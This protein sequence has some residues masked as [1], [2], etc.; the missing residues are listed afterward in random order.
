MLPELAERDAAGEI[1]RIYE[2]FRHYCAVPYVSSL[3]RHLA[4]RAGWLEWAWAA[5]GPVFV[6]GSGP[7]AAWAAAAEVD[8]APLPVLGSAG[9]AALGFGADDV[10]AVG[11]VCET[12]IRASPTNLM[13]SGILRRLLSGERSHG[14]SGKSHGDS[15]NKNDSGKWQPPAPLP[16]PPAMVDIAALPAAERAVLMRF[17]ATVD[18]VAFVPGPYR[19]LANWPGLLAHLAEVL[20]P[21]FDDPATTAACDD[22]LARID[23]QV[24]GVMAGLPPLPAAPALPPEAEFPAV[25]AALDSYR[26]TSPQMVV[27]STLIRDAVVGE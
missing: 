12:F 2:A 19:M 5:V 1:A 9:R 27:F 16:A 25:L 23:A 14:D 3:Q 13:F 7:A 24:P 15:G 18:G 8:I 21:R 11:A 26:V 20:L 17:A 10:A 4:T 6:D 22:L